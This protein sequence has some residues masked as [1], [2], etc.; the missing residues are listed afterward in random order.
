MYDFLIVGA[1]AFGAAAARV[2]TDEGK[3]CLV[4]DRRGHIAG[5]IYT[6]RQ[7]GIDVHVY[8]AHIFHTDSQRVWDFVNRFAAF[9]HYR[10]TVTANFKGAIYNLPFNMNT[11]NKL[12]GVVRPDE[13]KAKIAEQSAGVTNPQ[14]LEEQAIS[15]VGR[16]IYETLIKGYT[17]KQWGRPCRELPA[18]IIKRLPVRFTF[19]NSYFD[20]RC[21]GIPADGFTDLIER[22]LEGVEVRLNTRYEPELAETA[23][24]VIYTGAIDEYFGYSLGELAYRGLRFETERLDTD[25]L[26]GCAVMNYTDAATPFTRIHEHK[27]FVFNHENQKGTVITHEYPAAWRRGDEAYYPVNDAENNALYARYKRLAAEESKVLFGGRLGTYRYLD[28][29]KVIEEALILAE[30]LL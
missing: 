4:I 28:I 14:N 10:H 19:D 7:N 29:D 25:N 30:S 26:Q 2:L 27:H 6:E 20:N 1:G 11:F 8:G 9:N 21:Q 22:M 24:K 13:A 12:W 16:D 17:E 5:N 23:E 15:L 18:S 3:R